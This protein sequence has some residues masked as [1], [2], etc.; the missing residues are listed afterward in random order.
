[1]RKIVF[2]VVFV[3]LGL[4]VIPAFSQNLK[5]YT[6]IG[7]NLAEVRQPRIS[8]FAVVCEISSLVIEGK[9]LYVA[10]SAT[11]NG[12]TILAFEITPQYIKQLETIKNEGDMPFVLFTRRGTNNDNYRFIVDRIIALKNVFG[13]VSKD[14]PKSLTTQDYS[15]VVNLYMHNP[16]IDPDGRVAEKVKQAQIEA[17]RAQEVAHVETARRLDATNREVYLNNTT[18]GGGYKPVFRQNSVRVS[19]IDLYEKIVVLGTVS[20]DRIKPTNIDQFLYLRNSDDIVSELSD[21]RYDLPR[22]GQQY[23]VILFLTKS[24]RDY[25]LDHYV[26]YYNLIRN[27]LPEPYP[28]IRQDVLDAWIMENAD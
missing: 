5:D 11:W 3:L 10:E 28:T 18:V 12:R 22:E 24:G 14:L 7:G 21:K 23:Q 8:K 4:N 6:Y 27:E 1:M 2:S 9:T 26:F 15:D 25:A 13:V 20:G 17:E 19:D 16:R